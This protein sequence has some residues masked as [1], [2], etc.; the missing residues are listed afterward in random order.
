MEQTLKT[1]VNLQKVNTRLEQLARDRSSLTGDVRR[2]EE[3]V[4]ALSLVDP[5]E[6]Q[7]ERQRVWQH[8]KRFRLHTRSAKQSRAQLNRIEQRWVEIHS[9]YSS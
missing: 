9:G 5:G 7:Q 4:K 1:L 8:R 2:Q 6:F 3:T